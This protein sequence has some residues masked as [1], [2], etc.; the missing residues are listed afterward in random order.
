[1]TTIYDLVHY[2]TCM[3]IEK[4]REDGQRT[5]DPTGTKDVCFDIATV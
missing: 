4:R 2:I 5:E 3:Q 1:M